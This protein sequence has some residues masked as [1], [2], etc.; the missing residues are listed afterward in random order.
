MQDQAGL[1]AEVGR[2]ELEPD[3]EQA[4][5]LSLIEGL[6]RVVGGLRAGRF[7]AATRGCGFCEFGDVC[8]VTR[9]VRERER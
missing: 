3:S 9:A 5:P 2:C 4:G 1:A 6:R 8:R 7:P